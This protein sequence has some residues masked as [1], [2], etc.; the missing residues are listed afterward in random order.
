MMEKRIQ[1]I[2]NASALNN[3]RLNK[4]RKMGTFVVGGLYFK[5]TFR[6]SSGF[7]DTKNSNTRTH[8]AFDCGSAGAIVMI[9]SLN[10]T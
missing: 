5:W 4:Q 2:Q 10:S 6:S 9:H 3:H 1:W 8:L 7:F